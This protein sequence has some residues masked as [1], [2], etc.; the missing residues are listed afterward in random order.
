MAGNGLIL[1]V[2]RTQQPNISITLFYNLTPQHKQIISHL[3]FK[4]LYSFYQ[5][6]VEAEDCSDLPQ[7]R[8]QRALEIREQREKKRVKDKKSVEATLTDG[9]DALIMVINGDNLT[10]FNVLYPFL[11]L[12][13]PF[14]LY[15]EFMQPLVDCYEAVKTTESAIGLELAESWLREYQVLPNRTH[16]AMNTSGGSGYVLTGTKI[17]SNFGEGHLASYVEVPDSN[18]KRK[19]QSDD[20]PQPHLETVQSDLVQQ[21]IVF[22]ESLI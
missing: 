2:Y 21:E 20:Q 9:A 1:N 5:P 17:D 8:R 14:V 6:S 15:S 18:K 19:I 7:D 22:L 12:G 16:P 10:L 3:S 13:K 11:G 4:D